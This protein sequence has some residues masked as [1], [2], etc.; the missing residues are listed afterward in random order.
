MDKCKHGYQGPESYIGR[1]DWAE[2][3]MRTHE[4]VQCPKCGL[5]AIW[6]RKGNEN[7]L[8]QAGHE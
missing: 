7:G 6:K 3:K 4:Q 2:Q 8:D 1:S 5:W